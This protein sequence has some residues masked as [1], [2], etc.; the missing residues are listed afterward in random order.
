MISPMNSFHS[1]RFEEMELSNFQPYQTLFENCTFTACKIEGMCAQTVLNRNMVNPK[2]S[3]ADSNRSVVFR[4]CRFEQTKFAESYFAGIAFEDCQFDLTT[5]D[6]CDFTGVQS[7]TIWWNTQKGDPF[8]VFIS[9]VLEFIGRQCGKNSR[10]HEV[11][12][13]YVLDYG[14]GKTTS[15]DF[16][17]CLYSNKVPDSELEQIEKD[18]PKLMAKFPF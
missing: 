12:E 8:T 17:A 18:L 10:A 13:R 3:P 9:K 6:H 15:K 7:E 5:A 11:F 16:S 14:T 2:L 1:C 4:R